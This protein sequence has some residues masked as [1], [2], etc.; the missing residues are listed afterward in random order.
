MG[1][2]RAVQQEASPLKKMT[3]PKVS[4]TPPRLLRGTA[5]ICVLSLLPLAGAFAPQHLT[6][7]SRRTPRSGVFAPKTAFAP[8]HSTA[9]TRRASRYARCTGPS[10]AVA[11][12]DDKVYLSKDDMYFEQR[13]RQRQKDLEMDNARKTRWQAQERFMAAEGATC[14]C[15]CMCVCVRVCVR[16]HVCLRTRV[17]VRVFWVCVWAC[18]C[19]V[20]GVGIVAS[21]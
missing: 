11:S 21:L 8:Q 20:C 15:L 12:S 16:L 18:V 19:W 1:K 10:R 3:G 17:R 4:M 6:A 7:S 5:F 14:V 2:K 13:E 9:N